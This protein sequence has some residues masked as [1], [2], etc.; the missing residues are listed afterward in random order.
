MLTWTV[1]GIVFIVAFGALIVGRRLR[2]NVFSVLLVTGIAV[3]AVAV[4]V[5]QV[6]Q[7]RH[8]QASSSGVGT[9][10]PATDVPAPPPSTGQSWQTMP[11]MVKPPTGA[12]APPAAQNPELGR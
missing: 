1:I 6:Q 11:P 3:L 5:T 12:A 9:S 2:A 4:T 7:Y 10:Q 8:H